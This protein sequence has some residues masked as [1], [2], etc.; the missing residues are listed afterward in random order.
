M[1]VTTA[2]DGRSL[3][4]LG[5]LPPE[6]PVLPGYRA[7]ELRAEAARR[8]EQL[9]AAPGEV[10]ALRA[11]NDVEWVVRLLSL[12]SSGARPLLLA[13][14]CPDHERN[15]L[16]AT[17]GGS[18]W[19]ADD[20]TRLDGEPPRSPVT[21]PFSD[22]VLLATSGSTGAPK[23]VERS[24]ASLVAEAVRYRDAL[25]LDGT[26]RLLLPLPLSHAYA[27]GWLAAALH[28]GTLV[29]PCSPSAISNIASELA[30]DGALPGGATIVA[31][32]PTLARLLAQRQRQHPSP[33]PALQIAMIGA[34]TVDE[35]LEHD[36]RAAFGVS[37]A[38]NYG[39][40]ETGAVL[41]GL[42]ELP[43]RCAGY[44]M[45]GV[46]IRI[47]DERNHPVA[48][49]QP[50]S[51]QVNTT[52]IWHPTGDL[53]TEDD[54]GR[55][56]ILGRRHSAVRRGGRW[57]SPLEVEA[58]LRE[59]PQVD[60]AYVH[61]VPGRFP[62]E[63]RMLADVS[64]VPGTVRVPALAA[65]L[66]TRLAPYKVPD[67]I[68]LHAHLTRSATGKI[69]APVRFRLA[70]TP[71]LLTHLR[72]YRR[73][74]LLFALH[75]LNLLAPLV[76]GADAGELARAAELSAPEVEWLL[77]TAVQLGAVQVDQGD[78]PY[79]AARLAE[80]VGLVELEEQLS[81][82][83]L[84]R[85]A[86]A[87]LA[88]TGIADRTFEHADLGGLTEA[89]QAAMHGPAAER[90]TRLGLRLLGQ[91][92]VGRLLEVSAGPGRYLA[93]ALPEAPDM[94]GHLV[95]LGR[96]SGPLS[97]TVADAADQGRVRV[98][99]EPPE[100]CFDACVV[101]NGIHGPYPAHDLGWLLSRLRPGGVLLI[102]DVFLPPLDRPGG[103]IAL[104]WLT[105]GGLAWP[106]ATDLIQAINAAGGRVL[107]SIPVADSDC[108][109]LLAAQG[110]R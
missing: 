12:L 86:L 54:L 45:P 3:L 72:A 20:G 106:R 31:L 21:G 18:R 64:A 22:G 59:H 9:K 79:G 99:G 50:G 15:R 30:G 37:T 1:S 93:A 101:A 58:A 96:L 23:L 34:G 88:R 78:E 76:D 81:R 80:L 98:D 36:F 103:E 104:D 66:R 94:T 69:V 8:A 107:R 4:G 27:L 89:Y 82:S 35:R 109:F 24:E 39:S 41:A 26:D 67:E 84:T 108:H 19:L 28:T 83:W 63:E 25:G 13:A 62:D 70:A 33:V 14:D 60:D 77:R 56:T 73:S 74:E 90:R 38:R 40:T 46:R 29:L 17:G 105:H 85:E 92:T 75:R 51:L 68:R 5:Y 97:P 102:D 2:S 52:G 47:L 61:A 57:V 71:T 49:G 53:A 43:P 10:V 48:T 55:V 16:L 32:V 6:Q 100:G 91:S 110:D 95:R 42:A 7:G 65:F 44:P 11:Q 87:D